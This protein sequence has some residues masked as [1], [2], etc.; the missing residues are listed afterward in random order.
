MVAAGETSGGD[1][2]SALSGGRPGLQAALEVDENIEP[3]QGQDTGYLSGRR[4]CV[5]LTETE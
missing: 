2:D 1:L 5:G 3:R 4:S